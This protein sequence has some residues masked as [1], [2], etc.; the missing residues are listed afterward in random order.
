MS[1]VLVA[2]LEALTDSRLSFQERVVL[3]AL[4]SFKG[5]TDT[6]FPSL[7]AIAE[8]AHITDIPRVSKLTKSLSEKGW[9]TKKKRGFTGCNS[10]SLMVPKLDESANLVKSTKKVEIAKKVTDANTN[11]AKNTKSNLV[12]NTKYKEQTIEQTIEQTKVDDSITDGEVKDKLN[13]EHKDLDL[14]KS[15][16]ASIESVIPGTK[17]PN[18]D[19]W[20]NVIRLM[21]E[22]DKLSLEEIK[23][24]FGWA[25]NDSFWQGNIR[26]PNTLRK[27]FALLRMR[28]GHCSKQ[29]YQ[30]ADYI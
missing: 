14:A 5:K 25:N 15:M 16:F 3:L 17:E 1:K 8:R 28:S 27:Q 6:V 10:Y 29:S 4:Y 9:L 18:F 21:R 23:N 11:L 12:K 2:P 24:V 20:A 22:R 13:F 19:K 30:E 7:D 26:C